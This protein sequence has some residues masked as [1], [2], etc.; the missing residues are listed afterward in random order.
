MS[1]LIRGFLRPFKKVSLSVA[2]L[3]Y[4]SW[5]YLR[6]S[7]IL[8]RTRVVATDYSLIKTYHSLEKS[9]S[10]KNRRQGAGINTATHLVDLLRKR[11]LSSVQE[12]SAIKVLDE[13]ITA[14]QSS[15]DFSDAKKIIADNKL[16]DEG[17]NIVGGAISVNSQFL[18]QGQ[19]SDPESFFGS[20]YS[21]R[22]FKK[23]NVNKETIMRALQL[24]SKTPS[25]CNR[26]SWAIFHLSE[27]NMILEALK[28]QNGN[29]GFSEEI[30]DLFVIA[31]DLRAFESE[32][33]R[34]QNWVDGGLYAMS[35]VYACHSLG[36]ATCFLN[37]SLRPS[38]DIKLRKLLSAP[39]EY[40]FITMIAVGHAED[41]FKVCVSTRTPVD[42]YYFELS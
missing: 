9:L 29:R 35:V 5:R 23:G 24:A 27:K 16:S 17:G 1:K 32:I 14:S 39:A 19:M 41:E 31:T 18:L 20:R 8:R 33:E 36:L 38:N 7:G 21:V 40:S 28:L 37:L 2:Y 3:V 6:Y 4:D 26:Q 22:S 15:S 11:S 25:V 34:F 30:N 13:F 42:E 10:F 12:K